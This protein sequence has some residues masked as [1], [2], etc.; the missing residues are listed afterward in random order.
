MLI[1]TI[2]AYSDKTTKVVYGVDSVRDVEKARADELIKKG[3]AVKAKA[4]EV[5]DED[6]K[7]DTKT[8][9]TKVEDTKANAETEK[10]EENK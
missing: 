1:K 9:D 3:F 7:V 6:V 4:S 10:A 8:E 5:E 2:K